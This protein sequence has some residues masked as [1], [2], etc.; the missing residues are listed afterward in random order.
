MIRYKEDII[1]KFRENGLVTNHYIKKYK[2]K[3]PEEQYLSE[4]TMQK[5]RDGDPNISISSLNA[6]CSIFNCQ[7]GDLIEFV[8]EKK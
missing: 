8:P 1:A 2:H 4:V 3:V 5:L 6:L 7:P